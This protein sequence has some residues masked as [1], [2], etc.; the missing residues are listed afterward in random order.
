MGPFRHGNARLAQL[1]ERAVEP[2]PKMT[3]TGALPSG[4][5]P[6]RDATGLHQFASTAKRGPFPEDDDELRQ[7]RHATETV[8]ERSVPGPPEDGTQ[9]P[10]P[11][12]GAPRRGHP[13]PARPGG[14][15]RE[16]GA[17]LEQHRQ[18]LRRGR[19]CAARLRAGSAAAVLRRCRHRDGEEVGRLDGAGRGD[20]LPRLL[21]G[22]ARLPGGLRPGLHVHRRMAR[23]SAPVSPA[24]P[25]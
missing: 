3:I 6:Y 17:R 14:R 12:R 24:M 22:A 10:A 19:W 23:G 21:R 25:R 2:S 9:P 7:R 4:R 1:R 20:R 18:G 11:D 5:A 13:Q 8:V 15:V 16:Q